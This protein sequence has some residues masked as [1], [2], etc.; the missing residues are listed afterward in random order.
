M[1]LVA[2]PIH[3]VYN[4]ATRT[5]L[6]SKLFHIVILL[7]SVRQST[8]SVSMKY[9]TTTMSTAASVV[10]ESFYHRQQK[11]YDVQFS[12][13]IVTLLFLIATEFRI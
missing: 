12:R 4:N 6:K 2:V 11:Y 8:V 1:D 13:D 3:Y 7:D 9:N 10:R 5:C